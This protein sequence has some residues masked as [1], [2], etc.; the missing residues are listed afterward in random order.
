MGAPKL[1]LIEHT[2]ALGTHRWLQLH[3]GTYVWYV[4]PVLM[5]SRV[6]RNLTLCNRGWYVDIYAYLFRFFLRC[7]LPRI[8]VR[9]L[10]SLTD[11]KNI[12][13]TA[14]TTRFT[15][16][17]FLNCHKL[18]KSKI[19]PILWQKRSFLP[20]L[21]EGAAINCHMVLL[22]QTGSQNMFNWLWQK[23]GQNITY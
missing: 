2:L 16:K 18:Q 9:T 22:S 19:I 6:I 3:V 21:V 11:C 1:S 13:S 8:R 17:T 23:F 14:W 4:D 20:I 12:R 15:N 7:A 5:G 10:K